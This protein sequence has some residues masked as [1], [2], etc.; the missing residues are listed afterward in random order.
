MKKEKAIDSLK[1]TYGTKGFN[2]LKKESKKNTEDIAEVMVRSVANKKPA[3]LAKFEKETNLQLKDAGIVDNQIKKEIITKI[4]KTQFFRELTENFVSDEEL[5]NVYKDA[6][7]AEK[8]N[9]VDKDPIYSPDHSI[10]LSA[11]DKIA[12]F[13]GIDTKSE[14]DQVQQS[15]FQI[16]ILNP[17]DFK[18][19]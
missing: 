1:D 2:K 19:D 14:D 7:S 10:R 6:L 9:V 16:N 5:L 4:Q 17:N 3:T 8:I 11:A 15:N 18:D 13:K 12:K